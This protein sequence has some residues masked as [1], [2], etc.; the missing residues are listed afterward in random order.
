MHWTTA[1]WNKV[2]IMRTKKST[3]K[4]N[5]DNKHEKVVRFLAP[6]H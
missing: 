6:P 3:D 1:I 5:L 2:Q 4:G